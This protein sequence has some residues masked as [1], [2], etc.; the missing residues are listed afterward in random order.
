MEKAQTLDVGKRIKNLRE[1]VVS[2]WCRHAAQASFLEAEHCAN[3]SNEAI[4]PFGP[5]F[6]MNT[7]KGDLITWFVWA[8]R[9]RRSYERI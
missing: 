7:G 4:H 3:A 6:I 2:K 8:D 1:F 5:P 9:L